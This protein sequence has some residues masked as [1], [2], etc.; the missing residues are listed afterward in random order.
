MKFSCEK[1]VLQQA[2]GIASRCAASKSPIP[3]LEG[4]L[5]N[6]EQEVRLTGYDL[7]KGTY[8]S[9]SADVSEPGSIVLNARL[10][11]DIVRSLPD[12]IL[13]IDTKNGLETYIVCGQSEFSI[14]GLSGAEY[15]ALPSV[16]KESS[17]T[18]PQNVLGKMIRQTSFAVSDNESRPVY[19]GELFD[20]E[21]NTLTI[22]AI[23]G[24][25][26][27]LRR[28]NIENGRLENGSFIVPGSV[29][30]D[31]EKLCAD[32]DDSVNITVGTKHISFTFDNTVV[33]S[34]RLEGNFIDYKKSI[35][36]EFSYMIDVEREEFA[37]CVGRVSLMIDDRIKSPLRIKVED[38]HILL[39]CR[40][41]IGRG[42]DEF[43]GKNAI[44]GQITIGLNNRYLM[45]ALRAAPADT[46]RLG[47][48][49]ASSPCVIF[50]VDGSD[51]FSY[52][53]LPIRLRAED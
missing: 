33:I 13:T 24:Y 4:I 19:M 38:D 29:L 49:T 9:F 18:L 42:E 52:M 25:R 53:I 23:D 8:T 50:P 17:V 16:D 26:L 31:V 5:I 36:A 37:R 40:S 39:R 30:S 3:E 48:N 27:A 22:V 32:S 41:A 47:I 12:D 10:F 35:P 1:Y 20:I 7:K 45:D 46:V 21:E 2:I 51:A 43:V 15:P 44:D 11:S 6:A 14:T 28:E 34:R